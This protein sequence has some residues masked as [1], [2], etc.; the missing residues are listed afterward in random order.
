MTPF[1]LAVPRA[2]ALL[3]LLPAR[4]RACVRACAFVFT[5]VS[6]GAWVDV[7]TV[8]A[9]LDPKSSQ[10]CHGLVLEA[11]WRAILQR[12]PYGSPGMQRRA[13]ARYASGTHRAP[14]SPSR[15]LALTTPHAR[16]HVHPLRTP[17]PQ[18]DPQPRPRE[19]QRRAA[20]RGA[21]AVGAAHAAGHP[22]PRRHGAG[23]G[24]VRAHLEARPHPSV[25]AAPR[26]AVGR[27]QRLPCCS[28]R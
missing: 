25:R 16:L 12:F 3:V 18:Q 20:G 15:L 5:S 14:V 28:P 13:I 11:T 6:R 27:A 1:P 26:P 19:R 4:V 17:P 24:Q 8:C 21:A 22:W 10:E 9:A 7:C 2:H 23:G